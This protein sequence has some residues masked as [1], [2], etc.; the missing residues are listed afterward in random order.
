MPRTL[1]VSTCSQPKDVCTYPRALLFGYAD[2]AADVGVPADPP[3]VYRGITLALN[4]GSEAEVD[5]ALEEAVAVGARLIKP[6][7]RAHWGGYSGYF[8]DPDGHLREAAYAPSFP[9]ANDG[10]IDIQN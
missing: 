5:E 1:S 3:T 9:V 7:E 6:A 10:T 2:L 4:F 8:A